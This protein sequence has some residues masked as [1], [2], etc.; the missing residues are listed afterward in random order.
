METFI[1]ENEK[2][3]I[4]LKI[5]IKKFWEGCVAFLRQKYEIQI[6]SSH[7]GEV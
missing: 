1:K 7:F 3:E 6:N 4:A 5:K 2:T